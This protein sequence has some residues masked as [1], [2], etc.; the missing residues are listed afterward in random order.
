MVHNCICGAKIDSNR[1]HALSC[2]RSAGRHFRYA[3]INNIVALALGKVDIP[4][5]LE[6][7][8]LVRD[9]GRRP[10]WATLVP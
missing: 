2:R 4:A 8:N 9:D 6:P 1:L 7:T 5:R 3:A 10:D